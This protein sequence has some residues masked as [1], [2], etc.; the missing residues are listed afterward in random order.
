MEALKAEKVDLS[1][2]FE[3]KSKNTDSSYFHKAEII[4]VVSLKTTEFTG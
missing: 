2:C 4:L 1:L 3:V